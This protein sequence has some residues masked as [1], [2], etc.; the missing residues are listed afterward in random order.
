MQKPGSYP[1]VLDFLYSQLP[2][3]QRVGPAAF[4]KD[5]TNIKLLV[6][7]LGNPH[8]RFPS[9]HIAGTNGKGSTTHILAN[10]LRCA[11]YRVGI[12]TSPHFKDYRERIKINRDYITESAVVEFVGNNFDLIASIRPSFFEITVAMAFWYFDREKVDI[13]VIETGLGGRLD[14]TNVIHPQLSIIT[15]IGFDHME[16]LGDT[17]QEIALEKAG[18]IKEGVPC[19]IG[20]RQIETT[21]IFEVNAQRKGAPIFFSDQ[22]VDVKSVEGA[23]YPEQNYMVQS[24]G[25]EFHFCSNLSTEVQQK[26]IRTALAAYKVLSQRDLKLPWIEEMISEALANIPLD[27]AYFGRFQ[28]LSR[29]PWVI[30]DGAHNRDGLRGLFKEV[31]KIRFQKL[32][33]II[34]VVRDK[35]LDLVISELPQDANYISTQ[36]SVPRAL[37]AE[38]LQDILTAN[39]LHCELQNSPQEA[40]LFAKKKASKN[41]VILITGSMFLVAE[42]I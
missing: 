5:L 33:I 14:S 4:K 6:E 27:L 15:N 20:E 37:P 3:F 39:D 10:L 13:A 41:D 11:G 38:E 18:I 12:Y 24:E 40:Y 9:I 34:G 21:A 19:V 32:W 23:M 2:M 28:I 26:N 22:L 31:S 16:F 25:S 8:D 7:G 30:A 29:D 1:E 42:L 36:A 17:L 35:S